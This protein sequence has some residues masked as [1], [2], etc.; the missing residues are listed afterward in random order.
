METNSSIDIV[1][2]HRALLAGFIAVLGIGVNYGTNVTTAADAALFFV[3][4]V[5]IGYL[6]FT[7]FSLLSHRFWWD[8]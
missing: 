5:V 7:L 2:K 6:V 4:S 3:V 1:N 8:H